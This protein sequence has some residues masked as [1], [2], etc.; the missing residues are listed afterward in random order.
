MVPIENY[1]TD[2]YVYINK[3]GALD[4]KNFLHKLVNIHYIRNDMVLEPGSFRVMGDVI[5]IFPASD[6]PT[7]SDTLQVT[8]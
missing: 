3:L 1:G 5:E 4:Q 6:A 7:P 2:V 8:W